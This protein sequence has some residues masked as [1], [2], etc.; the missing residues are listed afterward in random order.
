VKVLL[1]V[2]QKARGVGR[3]GL[4]VAKDGFDQEIR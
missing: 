4:Q 2:R 3:L 1:A